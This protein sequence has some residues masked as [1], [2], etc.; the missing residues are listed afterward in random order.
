MARGAFRPAA[1]SPIR[2]RLCVAGCG[3]CTTGR[4]V[5]VHA[6]SAAVAPGYRRLCMLHCPAGCRDRRRQLERLSAVSLSRALW[7]GRP[8]L[9]QGHQFLSLRTACLY[10]R[11][12]L[13]A[14]HPRSERA[15]RRN[16]LPGARRY[17]IRHS[18]PIDVADSHC[19][20]LGIARSPVRCGGRVL[21][22]RPISAALWRQ[23]RGRRRE[24]H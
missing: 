20:R 10:H 8:A 5:G 6:R 2:H 1:A 14:A 11:Q 22:P 7:C 24:L 18:S 16:H 17:R 9:R 13:D 19:S 15:F 12:E 4:S 21:W 3:Q 23:W